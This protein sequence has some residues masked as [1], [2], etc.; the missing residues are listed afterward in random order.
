MEKTLNIQYHRNQSIVFNHP[1]RFKVACCGRRWGKTRGAGNWVVKKSMY[2]EKFDESWWIAPTYAQSKMVFKEY[3][4]LFRDVITNKNESELRCDLINNAVT[5]FKSADKPDNMRGAKVKRAVLDECPVMKA[6]TWHEVM[7]PA[8]MDCKG[9]GVFIGTPKGMNWFHDLYSQGN[10]VAIP[11]IQSFHYTTM[12]NPFIDKAEIEKARSEMPERLFSQEILA[13]FIED[14]GGVFRGVRDCVKGVLCEPVSGE[15]YV[16]G[17]DLAKYQDFTVICVI[18]KSD[19]HVVAFDRFNQINWSLQEQRI[20]EL[21]NKY[22]RAHVLIDQGQVGDAVLEA[23]LM[24]YNNIE[25]VKFTN[26]NKTAM[27]NFLSNKIEKQEI[28]YPEIPVLIDELRIYEYEIL[29]SGKLRMN[30]PSSK[31]DDCVI[32]LALATWQLKEADVITE[33]YSLNEVGYLYS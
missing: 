27:I 18:R 10:D 29:A 12:D 20:L 28:S 31:H 4:R 11:D 2:D 3:N 17:V 22:N 30:A 21:A 13:E 8:L 14:I 6:E 9:E 25:G 16:M 23:L 1:A 15:S 33:D 5:F 32:A 26:E 24:K 19:K 7:R